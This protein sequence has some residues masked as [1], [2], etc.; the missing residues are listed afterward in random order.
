MS[1]Y[2]EDYKKMQVL[3]IVAKKYPHSQLGYVLESLDRLWDEIM[4]ELLPPKKKGAFV[5]KF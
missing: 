1:E 2:L 4:K 5:T 3:R